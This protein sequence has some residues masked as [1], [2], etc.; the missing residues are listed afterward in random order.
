MKKLF[1]IFIL[2]IFSFLLVN[3]VDA[4][5]IIKFEDASSNNN[6]SSLS[7]SGTDLQY[8]KDKNEY[9]VSFNLSVDSTRIYATL[10]DKNATFLEGY[11][12]R[13]VKLNYG[14]NTVL[15]KVKAQN[16]DVQIYTINI[17]REDN[18]SNNNFLSNIVVNG[19]A[20][21]FDREKLFYSFSVPYNVNKLDIKVSV[22][23]EK[24]HVSIVGG[25]NLIVGYNSI[26]IIVTADNLEKREYVLKVYRSDSNVVP[27][28]SNTLLSL[29]KV[30]NY[31]ISF[32][33]NNFTYQLIVKDESSLNIKAMA[34]DEKATVKIIDDDN[35]SDGG[36][37]EIRVIA[38]DGSLGLYK[39]NIKIEGMLKMN[40][41][42]IVVMILFL[43]A[44]ISL[45]VIIFSKVKKRRNQGPTMNLEVV[46]T[47]TPVVDTN[48]KEDQ[49]LMSF[50]LG[51]SSSSNEGQKR[52]PY[53]G[54]MNNAN[55]T[56]CASCGN[57]LNNS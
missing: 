39:I 50:L 32:D 8:K 16:G 5:G 10:E 1:F 36:A 49:Q 13:T 22:E 6:L 11:G 57:N 29:L 20:L 46:R 14:K 55:S 19:N 51:G 40:K 52:C 31:D 18:R 33:P 41:L 9:N 38:E 17:S 23:D 4:Y 45:S 28:S 25:N 27:L 35:I 37:V 2:L 43:V 26:S 54:A 21:N 48:S 42:L 53:C 3:K 34:E 12:P 47:Q 15:I 56:N 44:L 30:D 24:A 7:A